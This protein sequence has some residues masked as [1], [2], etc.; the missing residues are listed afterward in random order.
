MRLKAGPGKDG[1]NVTRKPCGPRPLERDREHREN[2]ERD[3]R[4]QPPGAEPAGG[5]TTPFV[6]WTTGA[7]RLWRPSWR[8]R[9]A[10]QL[11]TSAAYNRPICRRSIT[12]R[13]SNR[14]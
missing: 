3:D 5:T 14:R 11:E 1:V 2:G 7:F 13:R 9:P 12:L 8:L 4:E 10:R 6:R